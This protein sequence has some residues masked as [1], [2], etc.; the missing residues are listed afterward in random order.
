MTERSSITIRD[1]ETLRALAHP[2]RTRLLGALRIDGPATASQLAQRF[3][4]SSG[5]TS[6]H[7]RVLERA[8]FVRE[9]PTL[10]NRRDRWWAAAQQMTSWQL[11]DFLDDPEDRDAATWLLHRQLQNL[12]RWT[13]QWAETATE[14]PREWIDAA[15]ISDYMLRLTPA[16][17]TALKQELS[18]VIERHAAAAD[19]EPGDGTERVVVMTQVIPLKE[20]PV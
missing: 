9:D 8:G 17:A 5:L 13:T 14:W 19:T 11:T 1:S 15:D 2:L 18:D 16:A 20:L 3:G 7:L 6:Y 12:Q 4:E 10:G